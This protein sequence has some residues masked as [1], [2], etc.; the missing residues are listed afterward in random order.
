LIP[1]LP[2]IRIVAHGPYIVSGS[3]PLFSATIVLN[4]EDESVRW[5]FGRRFAARANYALCRCGRTRTP[6][7]CDGSHARVHFDGKETA[8][9]APYIEQARRITGPGLGL[10]DAERLCA[11]ARFCL[12]VGGIWNLIRHSSHDEARKAAIHEAYDCPAGRLVVWDLAGKALEP[13]LQ[14]GIGLV[15]DPHANNRGPAWVRGGIP[16]ESVDGFVYEVRN[17]MTLC[18]CGRSRNKPFCN[19]SHGQPV[20]PA[21]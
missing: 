3:V 10:T 16:V 11:S 7:F 21:G 9:R 17:R 2:R 5:R 18:R 4:D 13:E 6:P 19:G 12:R 15:K 1:S 14:I 20:V 8:S